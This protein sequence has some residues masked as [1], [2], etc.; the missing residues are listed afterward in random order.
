[1]QQRPICTARDSPGLTSARLVDFKND[2]AA[3]NRG[4][5]PETIYQAGI[6]AFGK[7]GRA[8]IIYLVGCFRLIGRA[9]ERLR[10]RRTW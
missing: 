3:L 6:D 9:P 1:M 4:P 8:E 2:V 10:R 5:L 7:E